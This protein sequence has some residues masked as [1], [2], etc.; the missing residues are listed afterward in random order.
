MLYLCLHYIEQHMADRG[1]ELFVDDIRFIQDWWGGGFSC[2]RYW[3]LFM[4]CSI[5]RPRMWGF[6]SLFSAVLCCGVQQRLFFC[7]RREY[8]LLFCR[9]LIIIR[10][11]NQSVIYYPWIALP[12]I[13]VVHFW[14]LETRRRREGR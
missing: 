14:L 9:M 4:G 8:R 2:F 3:W 5:K 12:G 7:R 11:W 1:V 10:L 6:L 13:L